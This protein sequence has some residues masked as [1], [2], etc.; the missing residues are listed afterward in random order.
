MAEHLA[1]FG[2]DL[3]DRLISAALNNGVAS[4]YDYDDDDRLTGLTQTGP[5]PGGAYPPSMIVAGRWPG[6]A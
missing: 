3:A 2:Y 1:D 6:T 4:G 5:L